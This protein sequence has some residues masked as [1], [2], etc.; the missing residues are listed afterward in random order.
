MRTIGL[1]ALGVLMFLGA[2]G[3]P[4]L[5]GNLDLLDGLDL[6]GASEF[7]SEGDSLVMLQGHRPKL[8]F[9][10]V[11]TVEYTLGI[12]F[13]M[14][15]SNSPHG[16]QNGQFGV[17]L[18]TG[19]NLVMLWLW[20]S[21][22]GGDHGLTLT[23]LSTDVP[24]EFTHRKTPPDVEFHDFQPHW[25]SINV[26][27]DGADVDI[28]VWIDEEY[29]LGWEGDQSLSPL[30]LNTAYDPGVEAI[31][32]TNWYEEVLFDHVELAEVSFLGDL[33]G[34][35]FVGQTDL[36]AVLLDW[37][38]SPPWL[39]FSDPSGDGLVSQPDLDIVLADWG[40]G[41]PPAPSVPEPATLS[42]LTLASLALMRRKRK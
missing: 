4:A 17:Y 2:N 11:P 42:L 32:F 20:G 35:G 7:V 30:P 10:H 9:T 23:G 5:A 22:G 1:I 6:S 36:D 16:P 39:P 25:A 12:Q 34:D 29:V 27:P 19:G 21:G 14:R 15:D 18:P 33:N 31:G 8:T 41:I 40:H 38:H 3:Q 37:G 13:T 28:S 24:G 26:R